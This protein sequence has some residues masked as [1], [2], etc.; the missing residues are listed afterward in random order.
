MDTASLVFCPW[1]CIFEVGLHT[2][3]RRTAFPYLYPILFLFAGG[4]AIAAAMQQWNL[5]RRIA[6]AVMRAI[7][8]EP[9]RLLL[10]SLAATAFISLWISNTATAAMM[11]PIGLAVIAQLEAQAGGRR[12]T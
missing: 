2:S 9:A 6:L 1:L 7:G 5:H 12:L 10:G 4:M 3:L 8:A 11:F